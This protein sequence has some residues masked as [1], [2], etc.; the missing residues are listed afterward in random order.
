MPTDT[1]M[2][3]AV[4]VRV[5][6]A[7]FEFQGLQDKTS[8]VEVAVDFKAQLI[9]ENR[10]K[11]EF[12]SKI[13]FVD[14]ETNQ[15]NG[16]VEMVISVYFDIEFELPDK[17]D[18]TVVELNRD[19]SIIAAGIFR[20]EVIRLM[21]ASGLKTPFV[22]PVDLLESALLSNGQELL[23]MERGSVA[24]LTEEVQEKAPKPKRSS[25]KQSI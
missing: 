6:K 8:Q 3:R 24:E 20:S 22:I 17:I 25:K 7:S 18:Q 14:V 1:F 13:N 4:D 16:K 23:G 21:R 19:A 9:E 10:L 12:D 2:W 15:S 5:A 11:T